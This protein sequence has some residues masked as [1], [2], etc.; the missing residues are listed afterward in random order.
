MLWQMDVGFVILGISF[1]AVFAC[2]IRKGRSLRFSDFLL[3][4]FGVGMLIMG[5]LGFFRIA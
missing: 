2:G 1:L 5:L 4:G 3:V